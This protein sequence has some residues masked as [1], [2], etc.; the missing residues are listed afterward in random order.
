MRS[1]SENWNNNLEYFWGTRKV[2]YIFDWDNLK[3]W[4]LFELRKINKVQYFGEHVN[5]S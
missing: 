1:A 5:R 4:E 3:K 2:V